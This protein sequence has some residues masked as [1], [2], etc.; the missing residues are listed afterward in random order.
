MSYESIK[1]KNEGGIISITLDRPPLNVLTIA[2]MEELIQA[3]K[4]AQQEAGQLVLLDAGGKAFSAGVDV[5]DHTADKVE[6]MIDVFDR[7]FMAMSETEKPIVC[8]VNGAALGGGCEL[9]IFC[10]IVV[11]SERAKFGQPEIAVGVFPPIACYMMPKLIS[12]PRAMELLLSGEVIGAS[13][14]E[15]IGIANVVLP[16]ENF[17]EGVKD[18]LKKFLDKSPVVLAMTKKA[19]LSSLNK[20]F[21]EG[22]KEIDRIYLKELMITEDAKEGLASFMEKRKPVWQGK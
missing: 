19:A 12:W 15:Q 17:A 3:F 13:K 10:D 7:L 18:Y 6:S 2:M 8:A 4:W 11:A 5:A 22:I 16:A 1:V 14:A 9:P 20:G 21:V